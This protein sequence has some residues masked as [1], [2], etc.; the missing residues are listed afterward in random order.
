[1]QPSALNSWP[2]ER[3]FPLGYF[4]R[5]LWGM[6]LANGAGNSAHELARVVAE[7][8]AGRENDGPL[9]ARAHA[10]LRCWFRWL[11]AIAAA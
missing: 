9:V 6:N 1:M 10:H 4:G 11:L 7:S 8:H 3:D 2:N 5:S